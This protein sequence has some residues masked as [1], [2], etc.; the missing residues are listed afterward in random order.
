MID[1]LDLIKDK[2][3]VF[4]WL[5]DISADSQDAFEMLE[6]SRNKIIEETDIESMKKHLRNTMLAVSKLSVNIFNLTQILSI[7]VSSDNFDSTVAQAAMRVG[8]G[9]EALRV[10]LKNKMRGKY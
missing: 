7:Y 10:M 3:K 9:E 2:K 6:K 4:K 5:T 1:I 8:K